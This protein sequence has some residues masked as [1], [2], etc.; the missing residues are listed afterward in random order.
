MPQDAEH[1]EKLS[2]EA[3]RQKLSEDDFQVAK[4]KIDR[5]E[6]TLEDL[7]GMLSCVLSLHNGKLSTGSIEYAAFR[8]ETLSLIF[9]VAMRTF[10]THTAS[11]GEAY[12]HFLTELGDEVGLTFARDLIQRLKR[13]GIFL[14]IQE[15]KGLLELWASFEND[16]GAGET[17]IKQFD[18]VS[19]SVVIELR[20]NPLRRVESK[21]HAHCRFYT[22]YLS[23]LL[24][25]ISTQRARI[26]QARISGSIVKAQKVIEVTE[27]PDAEGRCVFLFK[28]RPEVLIKAFDLL[29]CAYDH[30]FELDENVDFTPC[31]NSA[32]AALVSA[33][34][35]TLGLD[36]SKSNPQSF[37]L[38]KG[39]LSKTDFKRMDETYQR[40]S[41][42]LH[43]ETGIK[44]NREYTWSVLLDVRRS[45]NVLEM[46]NL[47]EQ[48]RLMLKTLAMHYNVLTALEKMAPGSEKLN[49]NEIN[50]MKQL[51]SKIGNGELLNEADQSHLELI[52]RKAGENVW[53]TV[54]PIWAAVSTRA[55]KQNQ[56][57]G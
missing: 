39:V 11:Q 29:N 41:K 16:T 45:I 4:G 28:I 25:E 12:T 52:L 21:P 30:F 10:N 26:L 20:N 55:V 42:S 43:P 57:L 2:V 44:C 18:D 13:K 22:S 34:T 9:E 47:G 32:R 5:A 51:V 27:Q 24:N 49:A 38:F 50:Q 33:Q 7:K 37:K 14:A 46:L 15:M 54:Q 23:S 8:V 36:Q 17:K 48:K 56:N 1:D 35:E 3:I 19:G 40:V 6:Q 53:Q 31:M